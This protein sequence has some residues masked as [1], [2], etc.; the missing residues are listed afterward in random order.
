VNEFLASITT[1]EAVAEAKII[2]D[3]MIEVRDLLKPF[4]SETS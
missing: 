3:E 2:R 4:A 1:P